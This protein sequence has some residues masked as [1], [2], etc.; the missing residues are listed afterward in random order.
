MPFV[1]SMARSYRSSVIGLTMCSTPIFFAISHRF[2][3]GSD[4]VSSAAPYLAA[5][6]AQSKP[7]G[8]PPETSTRLPTSM[9]ILSIA[10]TAIDSGSIRLPSRRLTPSGS[11]QTCA[12]FQTT[13]SAMQGWLLTPV[14][15][16]GWP[17]EH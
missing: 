17:I 15:Y 4:S 9:P 8:P 2:A 12:S 6:C 1:I 14:Q 13:Y 10:R 5:S 7:I 16:S 3:T 11:L